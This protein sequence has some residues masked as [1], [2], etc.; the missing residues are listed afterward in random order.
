MQGVTQVR[1][2]HPGEQ[3]QCLLGVVVHLA[4]QYDSFGICMLIVRQLQWEIVRTGWGALV[5]NLL[6]G[7]G[8]L[9]VWE[10]LRACA[11]CALAVC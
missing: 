11:V 3:E 4:L 6:V 10:M 1:Q 7:A 2:C 9:V 8:A 5:L